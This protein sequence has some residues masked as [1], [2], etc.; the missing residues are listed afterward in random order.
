MSIQ[1]NL[2]DCR[3][4]LLGILDGVE[5]LVTGLFAGVL[6]VLVT[7]GKNETCKTLEDEFRSVTAS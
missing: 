7:L 5:V 1:L 6:A 4:N 3:D 2:L